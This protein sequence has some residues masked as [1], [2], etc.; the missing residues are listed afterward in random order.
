MGV[1]KLSILYFDPVI[2]SDTSIEIEMSVG[3]FAKQGKNVF[4]SLQFFQL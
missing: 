4:F 3:L 1:L 2:L